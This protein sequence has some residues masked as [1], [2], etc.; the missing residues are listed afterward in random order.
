MIDILGMGR[1]VKLV[2]LMKKSQKEVDKM[3]SNGG[4]MVDE[5]QG[6]EVTPYMPP[7]TICD[8]V[9]IDGK[10]IPTDLVLTDKQEYGLR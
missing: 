5:E 1:K 10:E 3:H 2:N 9:W 8:T 6:K 7:C 4:L